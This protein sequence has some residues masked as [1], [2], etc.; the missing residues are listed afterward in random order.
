LLNEHQR[1]NNPTGSRAHKIKLNGKGN[2]SPYYSWEWE[3][4]D[5]YICPRN[6]VTTGAGTLFPK[7]CFNE[8]ITNYKTA[9][10]LCPTADDIWIY[11]MIRLNNNCYTR[12]PKALQI[13]NS[14]FTSISPL[15]LINKCRN[16]IYIQNMISRYGNPAKNI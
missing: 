10:K 2:I 8:E 11:W 12:S 3:K 14:T 7:G 1:T 16:D 6:F 5:Q 4:G 15:N 13:T 9:S